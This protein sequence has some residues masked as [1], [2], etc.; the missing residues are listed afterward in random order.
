MYAF[1]LAGARDTTRARH[2]RPGQSGEGTFVEMRDWV[3]RVR[4]EGATRRIGA[5][6]RI[7]PLRGSNPPYPNERRWR[8]PSPDCPP[9]PLPRSG[10]LA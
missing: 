9:P 4:A 6:W 2:R 3:G 5:T 1:H 7:A 10:P 8:V